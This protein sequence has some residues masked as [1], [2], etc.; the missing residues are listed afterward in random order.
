TGSVT[1]NEDTEYTFEIGRVACRD[2]NDTPANSVAA[3]KIT[4]LPATGTLKNNGVAVVAGGEVS[5]A[6]IAAGKLTFSPAANGNG[7]PYTSFTFQVRDNG[8]TANGGVDLDQSA[9][10]LTVDVTSV[11]D[12]PAGTT[13]S[14]TTN[15]DTEYTFGA[16]DFGFSDPNDTPANSLA[17]V[18]ITTLPATGTLKNNGVA[19]VAGGEVSAADIAAG[20]LTFSPAANENG[21]PYT[22]FT[23]QVRDNGGTANGG[24]DLDQSA[25]TLT[26]NVTSVNDAPAGTTGSVTTNEATEYTFDTLSTRRSSDLDTPANSL[27]AVKITTLP[28]TGTL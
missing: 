9:N 14:V 19:V 6:D 27:A 10:T 8:G 15:E 28:A 20:K 1:T 23:F 16:A 18:K 22:S 17:A 2:R 11:N 26:V 5:A 24:V 3:V 4:T 7:T 25:N 13:G 12:A 21:T